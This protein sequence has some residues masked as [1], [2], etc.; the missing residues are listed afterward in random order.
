MSKRTRSGKTFEP[1]DEDTGKIESQP[2]QTEAE[3]TLI[4]LASDELRRC[5]GK[6]YCDESQLMPLLLA[7]GLVRHVR[8][9]EVDVHP[10]GGDSFKVT[11]D[12]S[13]PTV[14]E[15][16]ME[17]ERAQGTRRVRQLLCRVAV[18]NDGKAVREDD[19]EPEALECD[20]IELG[21]IVTM[22]V[23]AVTDEPVQWRT[24]PEDQVIVSKGDF[25]GQG[26]VVTQ[27]TDA[28]SLVT[29]GEELMEGRHYWEVE[30]HGA[31]NRNGLIFGVCKPGL[32]LKSHSDLK[33]SWWISASYACVHGFDPR[34]ASVRY[35]DN[36]EGF[37]TGQR[38]G[39]L[40]D[41]NDGSLRFFHDGEEKVEGFGPG[42][43]T[44][45]VARYVGLGYAGQQV[46]LLPSAGWPTAA[47]AAAFQWPA[48]EREGYEED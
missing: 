9:F 24:Y 28:E 19:Q 8:T 44:G 47:G 3:Q 2:K 29:T 32:D 1:S 12:A 25:F 31:R 37:D 30:L 18:G 17:I 35:D 13:R 6:K 34:Y 33:Q 45:P 4:L 38:V 20:E 27:T 10:L 46:E 11:L 5:L 36:D 40:L 14:G 15:V 22:A 41:L 42:S 23:M 48:H 7:N 39:M 16:K 21:D 26:M 43:V